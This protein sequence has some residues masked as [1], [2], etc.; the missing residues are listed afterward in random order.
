[1]ESEKHLER[2]LN[3]AIT[4]LGGYSIKLSSIHMTGLPD[5]LCILPRGRIFFAEMKT[6]GKKP[7][8]IQLI[9]HQR[10]RKLGFKVEVIDSLE[11]LKKVIEE[12]E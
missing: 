9:I 6:T 3:L 2:V 4:L 8:K 1:M 5:R 10:I 11:Q 7:T 12:Y